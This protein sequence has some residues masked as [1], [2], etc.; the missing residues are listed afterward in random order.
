MLNRSR[1]PLLIAL[2]LGLVATLLLWWRPTD[3]DTPAAR[4]S[5]P[6][7][8]TSGPSS[9][10]S[11]RSSPQPS[12]TTQTLETPAVPSDGAFRVRVVAAGQPVE[13]ARV[14]AYL[15][16]ADDGTG[17]TPWRR[18]SEGTT[19][20]DG[21]VRLPAVPGLYLLSAS[22]QGH[23][24][25]RREVARPS[26][27]AETVVEFSLPAGVELRGRVVAAGRGEPVPLAEISLHPYTGAV[28]ASSEAVALPEETAEVTSDPQGRFTFSGL[29]PGRYALTAGAAGYSRRTLRIVTVPLPGELEV[30]LWASSFLEG[31]VL[32]EDGEPVAGAEVLALGGPTVPSTSTGSGGG[33]SLEVSNGTYVLAA[34]QGERMG[35]I[36][37]LLQVAPG[38]TLR[39]LRI[40][41]GAP[42]GL[43]GTVTATSEETPVEGA[44]LVA[45][46]ANKAGEVGS[47][48][49]GTDGRYTLDLP[50][51]DYDVVVV[52]PSRTG[53]VREALVIASGQRLTVDFQLDGTSTVEGRVTD[54]ETRPIAGASVKASRMH[55][56][57]GVERFTRTDATGAYRL[58]GLALGTTVV[59][60]RREQTEHWT[61]KSV[62]VKPGTAAQVDF[63]LAE[64]GIVQGQVTQASGARLTQPA[65]VRAMTQQGGFGNLTH[66]DTDVEGR[67]QLELPAGVYQLVA[68]NP[69]A[70]YVF[71]HE[72]DLAVT[73]PAGA[74]VVQDLSLS[75]DRGVRGTVLEPSGAPSPYATAVAIQR[76]DFAMALPVEAD[77]EGSFVF[78]PRGAHAPPLDIIAHNA[79]RVGELSGVRE[80]TDVTLQLRPAATLRGR[81]VARSG[82]A[83]LGFS[84]QLLQEDG[85]VLPWLERGNPERSFTGASFVLYDA[86]ALPLRVSVRTTDGRTGEASVKLSPGQS[87]ELEVP[88]TGGSASIAGRAVWSD[89][90]APAEAVSI[91]LDKQLSA[92]SDAQTGPDGRF[93]LKDVKPGPHTL[94]VWASA[95]G[96]PV[97]RTVKLASGEAVDL[98]D[99]AVT[100]RKTTPGTIGVGFSE[101]RGW[102]SVAWVKADSPAAQ[103]GMRVGDQLL[104][105]EGLVV[106]SRQ[107]AEQ[108]TRGAPG[109][110]VQ[111]RIQR[112]DGQEQQLQLTR[113]N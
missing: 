102:V 63:S 8:A 109:S 5:T 26:G 33:F 78:P 95:D 80:D 104:A 44:R 55:G 97:T 11:T 52:A 3:K 110:P 98:G 1:Y 17:R 46:P 106:R 32:G 83:P 27:E 49:T 16:G 53:A 69:G 64:T 13:G 4:T 87:A 43:T 23:A 65:L 37:Q 74:A 30:K 15:R 18:A 56:P 14:Q 36:P 61:K 99:V 81:V 67:Y 34:R 40:T 48:T 39:G 86:P 62:E 42:S 31:F 82:A 25:A 108:R 91:Y 35:R 85:T 38:E 70:R 89:S 10:G 75:E 113:A 50:P 29:A 2:I 28:W 19:G 58:E 21:T 76:G 68:V 84:L 79:G 88:L 24:P 47:V 101:E 100:T 22:A 71:T 105:V 51:G 12:S 45:S 7:S 107:E 111:L 96:Q 54:L 60:A 77:E 103:A 73:V 92:G 112:A 72:D 57:K 20:A 90:K 93:L 41:L 9:N 6:G 66:A 59:S 94:R